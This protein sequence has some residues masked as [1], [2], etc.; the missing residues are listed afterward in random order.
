MEIRGGRVE[1]RE[2]QGRLSTLI[3]RLQRRQPIGRGRVARSRRVRGSRRRVDRRRHGTRHLREAIAGNGTQRVAHL[4]HGGE[5]L[6]GPPCGHASKDLLQLGRNIV[7]RGHQRRQGLKLVSHHHFQKA[8]ARDNGATGQQEVQR[9]AKAIDVGA[10]VGG[11]RADRLLG[12]H[13]FGRAEHHAGASQRGTFLRRQRLGAEP[14]QPQ[15]EHFD[16]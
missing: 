2:E 12:R 1:I 4:L 7:A 3:G 8:L 11:T 5:P 14:S 16:S 10:C 15:V 9:A 6:I 13:V